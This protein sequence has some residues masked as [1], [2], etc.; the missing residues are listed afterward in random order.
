MNNLNNLN[1]CW[2]VGMVYAMTNSAFCNEVV[3]FR[4]SKDGTL[5]RIGAFP[6]GGRGT[7]TDEVSPATPQDG[8][9]PLASQGSLVVNY[10]G[11][12]LFAVNAGSN[13]ISSF[14]IKKDGRLVLVDIESSGG[15]QPNTLAVFHDILYVANVGAAVNNYDSNITGFRVRADGVMTPI[16]NSTRELST[17]NAQPACLVF[18]PNG[19]FLVVTELTTNNISVFPVNW[20]SGCLYGP[21]VNS[22]YGAGPFGA[23][24]L[25]NGILLVAEAGANALSSYWIAPDGT[26]QTISGSVYNGQLAT[27]WV[28]VSKNQHYAYTSN[29]ASGTITRYRINSNG[30]LVL[31]ESVHTTRFGAAVAPID[32]GVSKYYLFA[33]NGNRGWITVFKIHADGRLERIK[34][35]KE[36]GLPYLG[37]Q[38]LAVR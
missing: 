19:R 31:G 2:P 14:R 4:R 12:L 15:L 22:S 32:I 29:S 6:T 25:G 38:G 37:S 24:F 18:S 23:I 21:V 9:D 11:T 10:D 33:L 3:A 27:C 30:T 16:P 34:V 7:G 8:V 1:R 35:K 28:A 36:T 17:P 26:L 20:C 5:V 13:S